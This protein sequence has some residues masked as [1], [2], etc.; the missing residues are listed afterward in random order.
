MASGAGRLSG[1]EGVAVRRP[2]VNPARGCL[3]LT[4]NDAAASVGRWFAATV[5]L[6]KQVHQ[7]GGDPDCGRR[8]EPTTIRGFDDTGLD[9][10]VSLTE[11]LPT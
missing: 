7:P 2:C 5:R 11:T 8:A 3:A 4:G 10:V 6:R 9:F 1:G